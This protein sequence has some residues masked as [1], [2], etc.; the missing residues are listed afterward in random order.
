[1]PLLSLG[2]EV[3]TRVVVRREGGTRQVSQLRRR[4]R[5]GGAIVGQGSRLYA[6]MQ[7]IDPPPM[8]LTH[9]QSEGVDVGSTKAVGN[10]S[11]CLCFRE[12]LPF[13]RVD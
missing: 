3:Q 11:P 10:N 5:I 12:R 13:E 6:P 9:G 7:S 2:P 4:E 8:R 1:M